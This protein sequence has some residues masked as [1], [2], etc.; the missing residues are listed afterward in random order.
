MA[1]GRNRFMGA[2]VLELSCMSRAWTPTIGDMPNRLTTLVFSGALLLATALISGIAV[3]QVCTTPDR[4]SAT[5]SIAGI[6]N[7]YYPGGAAAVAPGDLLIVMQMQGAQIN[8][9]NSDYSGDG[10]GSGGCSTRTA[11]S[12]AG[13][14]A[15]V[16]CGG[17]GGDTVNAY[18]STPSTG[19]TGNKSYA[20]QVV[21][22][23][24]YGNAALTADVTPLAWNGAAG[25][26][27][28]LQAT[29]TV[30]MGGFDLN[31]SARGF[32][33]TAITTMPAAVEL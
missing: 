19:N 18:Q 2:K 15:G 21:R 24:Q 16:A 4:Q 7:S 29:G 1:G 11:T 17:A 10:S 3:A 30:S 22:V 23:R 5:T 33:A 27:L 32:R 26:V 12:A 13:A 31:T 6:V 9:S 28:G 25:G 14:A 20:C 8:S